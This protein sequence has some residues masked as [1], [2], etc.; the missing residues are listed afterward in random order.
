MEYKVE[1]SNF[2]GDL[3]KKVNQLLEKDWKPTGGVSV[4]KNPKMGSS[5]L[6][7]AQALIK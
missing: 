3:Q 2:E 4:S 6:I 1:S 7:F 5:E